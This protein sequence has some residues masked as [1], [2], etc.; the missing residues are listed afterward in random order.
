[1]N[2]SMGAARA[3]QVAKQYIEIYSPGLTQNSNAIIA[4]PASERGWGPIGYSLIFST[5]SKVQRLLPIDPNRIYLTGQSMGGHLSYRMG[6]MFPD[7]FGAVS[8][9]SG[10]YN[11]VE[12]G[13]I[14]NLINVPGRAIFGSSEPYGI[15]GDNKINETWAKA[16]KLNWTFVEKDG[17]HTI[18]TDE[19]PDLASFFDRNPR[20]AYPERVY[21]KQGGSMLFT[22]TWG[23][24]GW[25]EHQVRHETRPMAWNRRHWVEVKPDTAREGPQE[26]LATNLGQNQIQV[27]AHNVRELTLYLHPKMVDFDKPITVTIND[28]VTFKGKA[29]PDMTLMLDRARTS[30]DRG[31]IFWGQL[32]LPV[33]ND[34]PVEL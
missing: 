3:M 29:Q 26:L 22:K 12:K 30:D 1:G 7:R 18:Y 33:K 16:H 5:I 24:Q 27:T 31:Q 6:L 2:S 28:G 25:P 10:G 4:A 13:S 11:F 23:I 21:L 17:G 34:S 15:N 9:H 19:L 20:N 8:P 14:G 32:T